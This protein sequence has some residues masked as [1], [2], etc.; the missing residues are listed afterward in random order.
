MWGL[1]FKDSR[2]QGYTV[3]KLGC[4]VEGVRIIGF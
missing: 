2:V 3:W 4:G 1:G